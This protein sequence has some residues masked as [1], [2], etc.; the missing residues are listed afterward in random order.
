MTLPLLHKTAPHPKA[1]NNPQHGALD[2]R[3]PDRKGEQA[4]SNDGQIE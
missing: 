4:I 1:S 3:I 2:R